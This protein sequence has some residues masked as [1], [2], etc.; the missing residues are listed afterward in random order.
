MMPSTLRFS[1]RLRDGR[2]ATEVPVEVA[3]DGDALVIAGA[4]TTLHVAREGIR[5]DAPLP[6][7]PRTLALPDGSQIETDDRAAI[8]AL[9]PPR[10]GVEAIAFW[11]ESRW[12]ASLAAIPVI[13]GVAWLIVA[14]LL[15]LAADPVARMI[16]PRIEHVIGKQTLATL[17]RIALEPS[18]LDPEERRAIE[19]RFQSFVAGEPGEQ[20]YELVFRSGMGPNALA[21]P[22]GI[23]I[24]TDDMV[25]L[26]GNDAE[27]LAVLA[28]EIGHVRGRHAIRLILQDSGVIVLVTAL[29]G[30]AASMT[31][32]AAALP[33]ALLQSHYSRAFE[34]EADAYAFAQLKRHGYSPQ[35]FADM[36]RRLRSSE[37]ARSPDGVLR[38]FSAHPLTEERIERAEKEAGR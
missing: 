3:A 17:D 33:T 13:A 16:G 30:D 32:L 38:Y 37:R 12:A 36:M 19:E 14:V 1:G 7:V 35:A 8:T 31:F 5:V 11:L 28:H 26:A 6:G 23:I 10:T 20:S 21:L 15:P 27:L 34:T 29:A 22:G 25:K 2:A 18:R 4:D 24:V 9:F